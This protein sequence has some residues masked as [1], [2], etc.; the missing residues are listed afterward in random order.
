MKDLIFI[1]S[2][3]VLMVFFIVSSI[4][5]YKAKSDRAKV[6]LFFGKFVILFL[7]LVLTA[8]ICG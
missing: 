8:V 5:I 7:M 2:M 6:A 4:A 3:L 1:F